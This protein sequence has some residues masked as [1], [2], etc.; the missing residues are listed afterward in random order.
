MPNSA[1]VPLPQ[2]LAS[3]STNKSSRGIRTRPVSA[4][5]EVIPASS[6][7]PRYSSLFSTERARR[8]V[9]WLEAKSSDRSSQTTASSLNMLGHCS[10]TCPRTSQTARQQGFAQDVYTSVAHRCR[11]P[12]LSPCLQRGLSRAPGRMRKRPQE[13]RR[14][15]THASSESIS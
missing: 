8:S 1:H 9:G 6:C 7:P 12:P 2:E 14:L 13:Q 4:G 10:R 3:P 11:R 5:S 15:R